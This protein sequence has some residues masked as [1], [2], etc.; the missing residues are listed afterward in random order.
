MKEFFNENIKLPE[1]SERYFVKDIDVSL[2]LHNFQEQ[3][4]SGAKT[5]SLSFKLNYT[6]MLSFSPVLLLENNTTS[7]SLLG[8]FG[9]NNLHEIIK[10]IKAHDIFTSNDEFLLEKMLPALKVVQQ[11]FKKSLTK[12]EGCLGLMMIV[13]NFQGTEKKNHQV[14]KNHVGVFSCR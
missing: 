11:V 4:Y 8:T 1:V 7:S 5:S 2:L 12:E 9:R 6:E 3:S 13:M 14:H 10:Q